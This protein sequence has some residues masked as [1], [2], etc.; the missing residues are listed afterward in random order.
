MSIRFSVSGRRAQW[1][2]EDCGAGSSPELAADSLPAAAASHECLAAPVSVSEAS[3]ISQ[4]IAAFGIPPATLAPSGGGAGGA[5]P[6]Q[7][8]AGINECT[9]CDARKSS[10]DPKAHGTGCPHRQELAEINGCTCNAWVSD[11]PEAHGTR[12]PRG[13]ELAEIRAGLRPPAG[14]PRCNCIKCD[15]DSYCMKPHPPGKPWDCDC[16]NR[17]RITLNTKVPPPASPADAI[18]AVIAEPLGLGGADLPDYGVAGQ[19]C[20][21]ACLGYSSSGAPCTYCIQLNALEC[22]PAGYAAS[23]REA[24]QARIRALVIT[25]AFLVT[26]ACFAVIFQHLVQVT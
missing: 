9:T 4:V 15:P 12:C 5:G 14:S 25:G 10:P 24:K 2:C 13:Q 7:P 6:S 21:P 19:A 23:R 26:L 22:L 1:Y 17:T 3:M 11:D 8:R 16:P 20:C 18:R